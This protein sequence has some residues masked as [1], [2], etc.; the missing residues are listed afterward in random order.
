MQRKGMSTGVAAAIIV[1]VIG[2]GASAYYI[3]AVLP[4]GQTSTTTLGSTS[5]SSMTAVANTMI[6][7]PSSSSTSSSSSS[8]ATVTTSSMMSS[9]TQSTSQSSSGQGAALHI[10]ASRV[11]HS[12]SGMQV[13]FTCGTTMP[14]QGAS[15]M[16]VTNSG[17]LPSDITN[18]SLNYVDMGTE[19]GAP[20]GAC[21]IAAGATMYIT[22]TGIGMDMASAGEMT[23]ISISGSN[24]GF[25]FTQT[26]FG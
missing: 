10:A 23:N 15:Y 3:G 19:S 12:M 9:S 1:V 11:S 4:S 18:V 14:G 25:T 24:G 7:A 2:V 26:A 16:Q 13:S 8:S 20:T 21:T 17:T 22:F 5:S 6:P